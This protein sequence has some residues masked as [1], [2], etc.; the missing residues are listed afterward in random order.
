MVLHNKYS[1][2]VYGS[3][4]MVCSFSSTMHPDRR[5][6]N[7]NLVDL[8]KSQHCAPFGFKTKKSLQSEL[9]KLENPNDYYIEKLVSREVP[10]G[11][12]KDDNGTPIHRGD[13]VIYLVDNFMYK[14]IIRNCIKT[15]TGFTEIV[16]Y[17][18]KDREECTIYGDAQVLVI[19]D[20]ILTELKSIKDGRRDKK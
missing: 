19:N 7:T 9:D 6:S 20:D 17:D 8:Y 18:E 13:K 4:D 15:V 14:G 2:I 1:G 16:I 3:F 12:Y 11:Y 10:D 5:I